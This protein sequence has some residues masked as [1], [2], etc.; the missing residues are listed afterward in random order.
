[1]TQVSWGNMDRQVVEKLKIRA[2]R[3]GHSLDE[4]IKVIL[5]EVVAS[6][7]LDEDTL[8]QTQRIEE[9]ERLKRAR[10]KYM[11]HLAEQ[12][13]EGASIQGLQPLS[14]NTTHR[15]PQDLIAAF[16]QLRQDIGGK[17]V[18]I[19]ELINQGRRF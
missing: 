8:R 5:E 18:P 16:R 2:Q 10:A 1:M 7:L 12:L 13:L 4:E 3:N 9:G 19:R 14:Q 15:P 6:E 17:D 11:P